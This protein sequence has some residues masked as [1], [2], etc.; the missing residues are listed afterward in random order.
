MIIISGLKINSEGLG[1][2]LMDT[3]SFLKLILRTMAFD[4]DINII[5]RIIISEWG[6]G[7]GCMHANWGNILLV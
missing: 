2:L 3:C 5:R 4:H 1:S 6:L 7:T